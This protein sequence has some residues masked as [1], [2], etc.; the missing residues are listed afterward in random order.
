[1]SRKPPIYLTEHV[2]LQME[3]QLLSTVLNEA[4]IILI[5]YNSNGA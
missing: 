4:Q 3:S 2:K 1:M 5:L